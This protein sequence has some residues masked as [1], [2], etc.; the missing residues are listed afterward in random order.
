MF[1]ALA[2]WANPPA[3]PHQKD[4]PQAKKEKN[5]RRRKSEADFRGGGGG[6]IRTACDTLFPYEPPPLQGY[7]MAYCSGSHTDLCLI[8]GAQCPP[9]IPFPFTCA[10]LP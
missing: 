8:T 5:F 3:R 1:G 9:P 10:G 7:C 4:F 2:S 6:H